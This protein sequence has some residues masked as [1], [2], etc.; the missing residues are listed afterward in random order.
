MRQ[1]LILR[2][3]AKINLRL[4][5]LGELPNKYHLLRMFNLTVEL[6]DELEISFCGQEI[7]VQVDDPQIPT[8]R[9]NLAFRAAEYFRAKFGIREGAE[10]LVR[11]RIPAAAG[12]AGGSSDAAAVLKAF[13]ARSGI[14]N[15]SLDLEEIAYQVGADVPYL[16]FGGPAW[17]EGIGD[18]IEQATDFPEIFLVLAKPGIEVSTSQVFARF[19]QEPHLTIEPKRD[20]LTR[21]ER[22]GFGGFCVN[23]L[24]KAVFA[25]HHEL[26]E[27]KELLLR[28]GAA[29][30]TMS[31]SGST[32]VGIFLDQAKAGRAAQMLKQEKPALWTCAVR[33]YGPQ[34]EGD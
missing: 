31:G 14:K 22:D 7:R 27:I 16:L 30:S 26:G 32:L 20:I 3:P 11:K 4:E 17:V 10:I 25:R 23:H 13:C 15:S 19:R 6:C 2:A 33:Q 12:L 28:L 9:E 34:K 18:K 24:E 21:L 5:V 8:G 1:V 29:A